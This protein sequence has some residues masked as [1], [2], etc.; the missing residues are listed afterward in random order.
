M[1]NPVPPQMVA[2]F[3]NPEN[4]HL[5][6]KKV[7]VPVPQKGE[8]L[9]KMM[10]ATIN[11]SDLAKIREIAASEAA[12]FIPG[13]E[14]CGTVVAAGKG[15][16]P[17]FFMGR[18]VACSA[19]Y[20]TSGTWAEYMVTPA[21]S[22]FPV[23][24]SI[25]GEQAA[26]AIVNPMTAL[27][28]LDF[29]RKNNHQAIVNTAATSALGKMIASLSKKHHIK[30]LNIVRNDEGV[31]ELKKQKNDYVLN[32]TETDFP[33]KLK[34]WCEKMHATLMLD[35]VGGELVNQVLEYLPANSTIILYGNLSQKKIEFS[36]TQLVRENKKIIGFYLGH[37]IAENGMMKTVINLLKV[38]NLLKRGMETTVQ[39]V[40]SLDDIQQA[41]ELYEKNMSKGKVLLKAGH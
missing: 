5:F 28:F 38:N 36:P 16:L 21:G 11:P 31:K 13:V 1:K 27:A 10:A 26:M 17:R 9:I 29:A 35:A 14:G 15:L 34:E 33:I 6:T 41:V 2:V 25:S 4:G 40:F 32:S 22:C 3:V 12:D 30:V 8:V 37:W 18:R 20:K 24:K 23:G 39:A 19:K 7:D